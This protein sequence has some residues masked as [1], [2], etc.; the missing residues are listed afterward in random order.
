MQKKFATA[1]GSELNLL[2]T[3]K[4]ILTFGNLDVYF[5][6]FVGGVKCNL[7]GQDFMEKF[8]CQWDYSSD[9]VILNCVRTANIGEHR[10]N[11]NDE[12]PFKEPVRRVPIFK[13][14]ILDAEIERLKE[15]GLIAESNSPWSSP[16]V[17]VQ[18]K[19]KLWR[20]CVDYRR[21][22]AKNDQRCVPDL[23]NRGKFRRIS[24]IKMD[25]WI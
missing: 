12:T 3:A 22:N 5:R 7:L 2:G 14:E 4:M 13:R 19:D 18:K 17:L 20:L 23:Q 9:R 15:Q 24:R 25:H 1:D 8:E 21:L 16:L 11:L 10:T 6:V